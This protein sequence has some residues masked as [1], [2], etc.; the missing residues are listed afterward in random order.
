MVYH[1]LIKEIIKDYILAMDGNNLQ[2]LLRIKPSDCHAQGMFKQMLYIILL[3]TQIKVK[4]FGE[5]GDGKA[6]Q[7]W[8][9]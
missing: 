9:V 1:I 7:E 2:N 5:Y 6:I 3:K 8:V 4:L